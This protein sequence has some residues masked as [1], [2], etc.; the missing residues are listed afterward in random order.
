MGEA[1]KGRKENQRGGG[2]LIPGWLRFHG[3]ALLM[4]LPAGFVLYLVSGVV[5]RLELQEGI[6]VL[7]RFEIWLLSLFCFGVLAVLLGASVLLGGRWRRESPAGSS[8]A[9]GQGEGAGAIEEGGPD[10]DE[11]RVEEAA[12]AEEA[13]SAEEGGRDM[14]SDPAWWTITFGVG[15]L[16]LYLM[17]W[18]LSMAG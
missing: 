3:S 13:G 15:L 5:V 7:S 12:F 18:S 8:D 17:A 9:S 2:G 14:G 16:G 6:Q 10:E 11:E 4:A 1:R